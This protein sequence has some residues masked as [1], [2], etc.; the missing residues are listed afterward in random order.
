M[1]TTTPSFLTRLMARALLSITCFQLALGAQIAAAASPPVTVA[2]A[3]ADVRTSIGKSANGTPVVNIATPNSAGVSHNVY[4]SYD[5]GSGGLVLNNSSVNAV[6]VLGG[7]TAANPHLAGG[8]SASLILNEV[9]SANPST[10]AGYQEILGPSAELV[11]A[12]PYG[13]TCNGCGF[14]N[15]PRVTLTTGVPALNPDGSLAGFTITGGQLAIGANGLDASRQQVLDLLARSVSVAGNVVVGSQANSISG[16]LQVIGG[17]SHFDYATRTATGTAATG[18]PPQFAIDSSVLGGMYADRIRLLVNEN[19]AG[20]R[21]AGNLAALASDLSISANG[22]I[23]LQGAATAGRD[24]NVQGSGVQVQLPGSGTYVYAGRN[25]EVNSAGDIDLGTGSIGAQGSASLTAAGTLTDSAGPNDQRFTGNGP[26]MATATGALDLAGGYWTAPELTFDGASAQLGPSATLYG[27]GTSGNTVNVVTPGLLSV[28]GAKVYSTADA[29]LTANRIQVDSAGVVAANGA[30]A[31]NVGRGA[32]G[33]VDNAGVLQGGSVSLIATGDAPS[34]A[35]TFHN[36]STGTILASKGVS[37]GESGPASI[38]GSQLAND[39]TVAG[40]TVGIGTTDT[41]NTGAIQAATSLDVRSATLENTGKSATIIGATDSTGTATIESGSITNS[42]TIW[43]AGDLS[44][45]PTTLTQQRA[46]DATANPLIGAGGNLTI[47]FSGTANLGTGDLQAGGDLTITGSSIVDNGLPGTPTTAG[48]LRYAGGNLNVT[49]EPGGTITLGGGQWYSKGDLDFTGD[50]VLVG[51]HA[52]PT[53]GN[54]F[55]VPGVQLVGAQGGSGTVALTARSGNIGLLSNSAV[56]SGN[57][58]TISDPQEFVLSQGNVLQASGAL[59]IGGGGH[60]DNSGTIAGGSVSLSSSNSTPL[61]FVNESSGAVYGSQAVQIGTSANPADTILVDAP[62]SAN[63]GLFGGVLDLNAGNLTNDGTIQGVGAGSVID[64]SILENNATGR[65]LGFS[66]ANGNGGTTIN[67]PIVLNNFGLIYDSST[68]DIHSGGTNNSAGAT[69]GSAGALTLVSGTPGNAVLDDNQGLITGNTVNLTFVDG[70]VNGSDQGIPANRGNQAQIYASNQLAISD[71]NTNTPI[72]NYGAIDSD[73]DLSLDLGGGTLQNTMSMVPDSELQWGPRGNAFDVQSGDLG[74]VSTGANGSQDKKPV[75]G[76]FTSYYYF[77]QIGGST[78]A[79]LDGSQTNTQDQQFATGFDPATINTP[80]IRAGGNLQVSNFQ[81]LYNVGTIS[82]VDS[83]TFNSVSGGSLNNSALQ[84]GERDDILQTTRSYTCETLFGDP[85]SCGASP[86]QIAPGDIYQQTTVYSPVRPGPVAFAGKIISNGKVTFNVTTLTNGNTSFNGATSPQAN[87]PGGLTPTGAISVTPANAPGARG[88][89]TTLSV[90]GAQ[91]ALPAGANGRF[92]TAQN[93]DTAPLIETNP[94]FGIDS[95][96]LGSDYLTKLLGLNPDMQVRRLGDSSYEDYLI[97][98]QIEAQTGSSVLAGFGYAGDMDKAL[99]DNAAAQAKHLNLTYG[100]ALTSAQVSSLKSDIVWMVQEVVNG[101]KVLVPVVYLADATRA[102]VNIGSGP[103][104]AGQDVAIQGGTV[105]NIGGD[106]L[107]ANDVSIK[108]TGDIQN[109]SGNISAWNVVLDAGGDVVNSTL[110][111]RLGDS[112]NGLDVAQRTATIQAGNDAVLNAGHDINVNGGWVSAAK[113]AALIAGNNVNVQSLV[114]T[115]NSH[116]HSLNS[117][118]VTQTQSA[119]GGGVVA[120][121]NAVLQGGQNV[122]LTGAAVSAGGTTVLN[123]KNGNVNVGTLALHDSETASQSTTGLYTDV[124][125]DSSSASIG[126]GFGYET[127]TTTHSTSSTSGIGSSVGGKQ[128]LID[129]GKGDVNINGS[130]ISAGQ[131]GAIIDS[132]G[133]VNITAFNNSATTTDSM[134]RQREGYQFDASADGAYAGAKESG[135]T[136]S[137]AA[138]RTQAQA[139]NITSG[140]DLDILGKGTITNEGTA[141]DAAGNVVLDAQNVINKAAQDTQTTTSGDTS[142]EA[143]QQIG[144]STN[145]TGAS[146]NDAVQGKSDQVT[147]GNPEAE[148]RDTFSYQNDTSTQSQSTSHGTRITAGGSVVVLA[149]NHASDEGTQYQAGKDVVISAADYVNKAAADTKSTTDESTSASG[150]ASVGVDTTA[151]VDV[152]ASAQGSHTTSGT[153]QST[154]RTGAINA[155]GSVIIQAN[156][157]DVTLEGTN[158]SGVKGVGVTAARDI[159]INQANDTTE[160]TST[161][162]SGSGQASVS[163]SLVGAGAAVGLGASTRLTNSDDTTSTAKA[164]SIKSGNG[165]VQLQAGGNLTSQGANIAAAGNVALKA[166]GDINLLAATDH[167]DKTG[168]VQAGGASVNVGFGTGEAEGSGSLGANVN[169][170][171]GNTDYHET[172]Q[173]GSSIQAGGNF[174][175][176]AG[177]NAH[178]QGTQVS[179]N[180]ASL[181]TGGN[182]TIESAQH[183]VKDNSYDVSGTI[184][185]TASKGNGAGGAEGVGGGTG[186]TQAGG[187]G[188]NAGGGNAQVNVALSK[189]DIDTNTNA[190]INT[191]GGTTVNVGGDLKLQDANINAQGGVS[192]QVAG[193]LDIETRADKVNVDQTNVSAYAGLGPVGGSGGGTKGQQVQEGV[194]TAA[195]QA[196][197]TGIFTNV[198]TTHK[199]DLTIGTA[200]G[201]SGGAGGINLRVGGNTTLTGATN[202][203]SD[204]KTQGQT[205]IQGVA[206]H[207]NDSGTSFRIAGT[208]ASA[209]GSNDGSG[210]SY[211]LTIHTP[212]GHTAGE[213]DD[214]PA[215]PN[216]PVVSRR[217]SL[218]GEE[219]PI[220]GAREPV[221]PTEPESSSHHYAPANEPTLEDHYANVPHTGGDAGP[222]VHAPTIDGPVESNRAGGHLIADENPALQGHAPPVEVPTGNHANEPQGAGGHAP[223]VEVATGNYGNAPPVGDE[224]APHGHPQAASLAPAYSSPHVAGEPEG[225]VAQHAQGAPEPINLGDGSHLPPQSPDEVIA[226]DP[227]AIALRDQASHVSMDPSDRAQFERN[228]AEAVAFSEIHPDK[229][230]ELFAAI[231]DAL[232]GPVQRTDGLW[233]YPV[234][235]QYAGENVAGFDHWKIRTANEPGAKYQTGEATRHVNYFTPEQQEKARVFVDPNGK[236]VFGDGTPLNGHLMF[237][238]DEQGHLIATKFPTRDDFIHHSSLSGGKRVLMAGEFWSSEGSVRDIKDQSG[239]FRPDTDSFKSFLVALRDQGVDLDGTVAPAIRYVSNGNQFHAETEVPNLL[240]E[241]DVVHALP[242]DML[243]GMHLSPTQLRAIAVRAQELASQPAV[244]FHQNAAGGAASETEE[245]DHYNAGNGS[246]PEAAD[247]SHPHSAEPV[248]QEELAEQQRLAEQEEEEPVQQEGP[249]QQQV[250]PVVAPPVVNRHEWTPQTRAA[251]ER[252]LTEDPQVHALH[253]LGSHLSPND[254]TFVDRNLAE[255]AAYTKTPAGAPHR[256]ALLEA[257]KTSIEGPTVRPDGLKEFPLLPQYVGESILGFDNWAVRK[258]MNREKEVPGS[259]YAPGRTPPS[260]RINYFTPE[261]QAEAQVFVQDGK[262]VNSHAG[263]LP[264]GTYIFVVD[265]QKRLIAAEPRAGWIHHSSLSAGEPVLAA[266]EMEIDANGNI[267]WITNQSGHFRP[268]GTSFKQ[269]LASLERQGVDLSDT[270]AH[271]IKLTTAA[272]GNFDIH[273]DETNL[274]DAQHRSQVR[275]GTTSLLAPMGISAPL[276]HVEAPPP[277]ESPPHLVHPQSDPPE[278][279]VAPADD[280]GNQ[281]TGWVLPEWFQRRRVAAGAAAEQ[282]WRLAA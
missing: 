166:G 64:A 186:G 128:V 232:R 233:T 277:G 276:Q 125:T 102:S 22:N 188:G 39:G 145:G 167:K 90:N 234:K 163:V 80:S 112:N 37:I 100:E 187:Q 135:D 169:F 70:L 144:L 23:E 27:S 89:A 143:K 17:A 266:G 138:T 251:V 117:D 230:G 126:I 279:H 35:T 172:T 229:R 268:D 67:A 237:V 246:Q 134:T 197:Q 200:S 118:D 32:S 220:G 88:G 218:S 49:A 245:E 60:I 270:R 78:Q 127:K 43:S 26:L 199:D 159:N 116:Q 203:A 152:D 123:A 267:T 238:V 261:E 182:L 178:L 40:D 16:D 213:E 216:T 282:G 51:E 151:S 183:I 170:E 82:G 206:T 101:H 65:I 3:P 130:S 219:P 164:A 211:G 155:G 47:A 93:S 177:G 250:Q 10:L 69:I 30:L 19:G 217:N 215:P 81:S 184:G 115:T 122:N 107:A 179:A 255:I 1:S 14:I 63:D 165:D 146:I 25:L 161:E 103:T 214:T 55:K 50:S 46:P 260:D 225:S 109:L 157:G 190:S 244:V 269:L 124:A 265:Q 142:W 12:N 15:T 141:L 121:G 274:L 205:I 74:F 204:F 20:V 57:D 181:A 87:L 256:E 222:E 24:I 38:A 275:I 191:R 263:R 243:A 156:K 271:E 131:G 149:Q 133:D 273:L 175:L 137:T 202:A 207:Q 241:H 173:H 77:E 68:L 194:S 45:A 174:S 280:Y 91:V 96:A 44:L 239:H 8:Q 189:Q 259:T 228:L 132:A 193:N 247:V 85:V 221:E 54:I 210:G 192:G 114:L 272:N 160:N 196:A 48:D 58:L 209:A 105:K 95:L 158:I 34:S 223:P 9:T 42:G 84:F 99:F 253:D 252:L 168:S 2:P 106:I 231:E 235:P 198:N 147:V 110:V 113:D 36:A 53:T 104:I 262:L 129:T 92:V 29:A 153:T 140:G 224:D 11:L 240:T 258:R 185:L 94:L 249:A 13:I 180:A 97:Q 148:E 71:Q 6:S 66:D 226:R 254:R 73:G 56:Y 98:Q 108:T 139:S 33:G 62:A 52:D 59:S 4:D 5:V 150:Q 7:G 136:T 119:I 120:G 79:Y 18:A 72:I 248:D 236:L 21:T 195:N 264:A 278:H 212:H 176:N 83:V 257:L 242:N 154:A 76:G 31:A 28:T 86:V 162:Q 227:G 171:T 208:I 75:T 41:A 111:K 61:L 201:I 281:P